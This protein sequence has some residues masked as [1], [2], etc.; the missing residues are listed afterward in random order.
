MHAGRFRPEAQASATSRA[1]DHL[2]RASYGLILYLFDFYFASS[3]RSCA[4]LTSAVL[5]SLC[6]DPVLI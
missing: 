3:R 5:V 6:T 2:D 1:I 4:W